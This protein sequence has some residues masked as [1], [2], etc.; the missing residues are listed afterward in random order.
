MNTFGE[1]NLVPWLH[2]SFSD[3]SISVCLFMCVYMM[4]VAL[5]MCLRVGVGIVEEAKCSNDRYTFKLL[6]GFVD[7]VTD[8]CVKGPRVRAQTCSVVN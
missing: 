4:L 8:W 6:G 2:Y 5:S 1:D 7:R 3:V